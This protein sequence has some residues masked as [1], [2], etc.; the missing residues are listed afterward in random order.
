MAPTVMLDS[1]ETWLPMANMALILI[2][3]LFLLVGYGFIRAKRVLW[4]KRSM[5][6]A[7]AFA[8]LFLVVYV[9]R[10]LLLPTKFFPGEGLIRAI[11]FGVL[12]SHT[13]VA[14]LVGPLALVTLRR[15]LT[16]QFEKHRT[17]ARLTLPLWLYAAATGWLVYWMLYRLD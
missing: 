7:T 14:V 4:H 12:V 13:I 11:Y 3:G 8:A 10:A 6:T 5:L 2:S 9:T 17:I 16:G 1:P 15:A